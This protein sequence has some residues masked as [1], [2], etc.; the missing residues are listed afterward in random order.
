MGIFFALLA[1]INYQILQAHHHTA[2][3]GALEDDAD[4]WK[5]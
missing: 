1:F 4:W 2:K 3:Y 5:R